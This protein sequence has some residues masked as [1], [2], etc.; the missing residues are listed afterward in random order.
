MKTR[1]IE[2]VDLDVLGR[3]LPNNFYQELLEVLNNSCLSYGSNDDTLVRSDNFI[4]LIEDAIDDSKND[5]LGNEAI[6]DVI[7]FLE[8]KDCF[9]ALGS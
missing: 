8:N 5:W 2:V 9:V 1:N 6:N 4:S 3:A 7:D